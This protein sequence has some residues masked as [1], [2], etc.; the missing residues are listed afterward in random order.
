M[1][2]LNAPLSS[3][4]IAHP[5]YRNVEAKSFFDKLRG[6][7]FPEITDRA[8]LLQG[9]RSRRIAAAFQASGKRDREAE[10]S[11]AL[12]Q[13]KAANDEILGYVLSA[14]STASRSLIVQATLVGRTPS[15]TDARHPGHR[16]RPI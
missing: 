14:L 10:E 3:V 15:I 1:G 11:S 2:G 7:N 9:R 16:T 4:L 5:A 8:V 13:L 12:M 6:E